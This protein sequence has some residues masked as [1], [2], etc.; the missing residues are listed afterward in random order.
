MQSGPHSAVSGRVKLPLFHTRFPQKFHIELSSDWRE[1]CKMDLAIR[2]PQHKY[3]LRIALRFCIDLK[4][5]YF[6]PHDKSS[7]KL[8]PSRQLLFSICVFFLRALVYLFR[9]YLKLKILLKGRIKSCQTTISHTDLPP[10]QAKCGGIRQFVSL[11]RWKCSQLICSSLD[12]DTE[13]DFRV[14]RKS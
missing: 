14:M 4:L 5:Y 12:S 6:I 10:E 13:I 7:T 8:S 1:I 9:R 3:S 11:N 2:L